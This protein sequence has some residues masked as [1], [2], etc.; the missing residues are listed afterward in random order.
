MVAVATEGLTPEPLTVAAPF[1]AMTKAQIVA[2]GADLGVPFADTWSCY[3][4]EAAHCGTCGTCT[5]RR[6]AFTVA[7]I[8]DPTRYAGS[9]QGA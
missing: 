8:A 1:L 4:G 7:G 5:E 3:R 2:L 6:E 9:G